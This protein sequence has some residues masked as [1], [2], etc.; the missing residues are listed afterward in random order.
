MPEVSDGMRTRLQLHGES[1][2]FVLVM[3]KHCNDL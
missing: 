2:Y 1:N 3:A